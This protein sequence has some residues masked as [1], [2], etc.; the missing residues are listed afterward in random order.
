MAKG[1]GGRRGRPGSQPFDIVVGRN[2]VVAA[3]KAGRRTVSAVVIDGGVGG[4]VI[5]EIR[6][7]ARE[8][9]VPVSNVMGR[10]LEALAGGDFHQGVAAY[11]AKLPGVVI[12]DIAEAA[13][14]GGNPVIVL[15]HVED[16]RNLGAVIRSAAA[17]GAA[18]VVIPERRQAPVTPAV[19][20][21][22][23]GGL[24]YVPVVMAGN[25]AQALRKLKDAGVWCYALEADGEAAVGR[26]EFGKGAALVLGGED[27]GISGPVRRECDA[28]VAIP[29]SAG[30][31]SLNV[32][33][34]AAV[35][36]FEYRRQ[37]PLKQTF[38][39]GER[40]GAAFT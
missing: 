15:D 36:L 33:A 25:V 9:H 23:E 34:A 12:E 35:A 6:I 18:G 26:F 17:L 28:V 2:S 10:D 30:V 16:P 24:E 14:A 21:A 29:L 20:K 32:A 27:A 39:K 5:D 40:Y 22:A 7:L 38:T 11:V 8:A 4:R 31:N 19:G 13:V 1:R 37:Y 3:L